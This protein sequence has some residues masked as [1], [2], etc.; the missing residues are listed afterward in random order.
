MSR[1]ARAYYEQHRRDC[2]PSAAGPTPET[3]SVDPVQVDFTSEETLGYET[4]R[5]LELQ[6]D[7]PIR[8]TYEYLPS[9]SG[10]GLAA[11][12]APIEILLRA[13]G[14]LDGDSVESTF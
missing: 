2:L 11:R 9:E 1:G 12:E 13:R 14:D 8:F 3:P 6:T 7:R 10:C 4:W 5:A